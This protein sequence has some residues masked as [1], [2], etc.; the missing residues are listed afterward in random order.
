MVLNDPQKASKYDLVAVPAWTQN[1]PWPPPPIK[2]KSKQPEKVSKESEEEVSPTE[3]TLTF[4]QRMQK[5]RKMHG[6]TPSINV[7]AVQIKAVSKF[8]AFRNKK[9]SILDNLKR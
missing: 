7:G 6:E 5:S 2:F 9:H 1:K 3:P 4:R 8:M